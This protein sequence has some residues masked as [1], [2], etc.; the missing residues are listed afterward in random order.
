MITGKKAS[1][2]QKPQPILDWEGQRE[3][4]GNKK[5]QPIQDWEGQGE[6]SR[7]ATTGNQMEDIAEIKNLNPF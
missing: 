6:R 7:G 1:S 2:K 3:R 4:R 5:S